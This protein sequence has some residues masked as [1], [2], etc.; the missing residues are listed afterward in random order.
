MINNVYKLATQPKIIRY[1][2][3]AAGFLMK[4]TWIKVIRKGNYT[5]WPGLT[6]EMVTKYPF[7]N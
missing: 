6:V 3:A 5:I 1:M 7:Q 4:A 2:H